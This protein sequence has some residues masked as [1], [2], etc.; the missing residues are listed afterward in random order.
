MQSVEPKFRADQARIPSG[1]PGGGQW[2]D[3]DATTGRRWPNPLLHP[4]VKRPRDEKPTPRGK[5]PV[6]VPKHEDKP[7]TRKRRTDKS[8]AEAANDV[9]S[10]ANGEAPRIGENGEKFARRLLDTRHGEGNYDIGAKS[11]FSR[12]KKFGDRAFD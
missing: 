9:P 3:G 11:E 6:E 1:Q 7:Q 8:A 12:L 4:V 2:T 5:Q 10:W